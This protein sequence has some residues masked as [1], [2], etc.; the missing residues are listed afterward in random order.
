MVCGGASLPPQKKDTSYRQGLGPSCPLCPP[1][2]S[3]LCR[4]QSVLDKTHGWTMVIEDPEGQA[5]RDPTSLLG[6]VLTILL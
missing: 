6:G 4:T 5:A 2:L 3:V 1:E